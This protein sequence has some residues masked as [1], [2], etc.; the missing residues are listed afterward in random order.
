MLRSETSIDIY[1]LNWDL[2]FEHPLPKDFTFYKSFTDNINNFVAIFS[3][4]KTV[5]L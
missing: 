2:F 4:T 1:N 5:C 3:K